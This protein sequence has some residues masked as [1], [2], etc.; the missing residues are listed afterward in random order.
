MKGGGHRYRWDVRRTWRCNVCAKVCKTDGD[1]TNLACG[2]NDRQTWMELV[3]LPRLGFPNTA[4]VPG[5]HSD[6][7]ADKPP[8]ESIEPLDS[9]T[10]DVTAEE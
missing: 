5:I 8:M 3:D 10:L 2:C 1:V 4:D 9:T 6:T 7:A